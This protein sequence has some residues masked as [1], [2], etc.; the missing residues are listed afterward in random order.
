MGATSD[1]GRTKS[2]SSMRRS[3]ATDYGAMT[4]ESGDKDATASSESESRVSGKSE[5]M[6]WTKRDTTSGRREATGEEGR[7]G[8]QR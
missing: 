6:A 4:N 5:S 8:M 7:R 2:C 3:G 1:S